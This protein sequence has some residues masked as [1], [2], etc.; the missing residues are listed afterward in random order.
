MKRLSLIGLVG[1]GNTS[2]T[3]D[4]TYTN[5]LADCQAFASQFHNT[6]DPAVSAGSETSMKTSYFGQT[7][8]KMTCE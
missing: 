1:L 6:C 2:S 5:T 3:A 7:P 4:E 8:Q